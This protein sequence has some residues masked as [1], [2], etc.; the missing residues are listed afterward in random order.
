MTGRDFCYWL[1]GYLDASREIG[2]EQVR[3]IRERLGQTCQSGPDWYPSMPVYTSTTGTTL[4]D[5]TR[6]YGT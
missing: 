5:L 1:E 6:R 2:P 4:P 3:A